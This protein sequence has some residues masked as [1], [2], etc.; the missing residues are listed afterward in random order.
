MQGDGG[1]ERLKHVQDAALPV[2]A[3]QIMEPTIGGN[4][5]HA[6]HGDAGR[7][8]E[9][10]GE[11]ARGAGSDAVDPSMPA[12]FGEF[13]GATYADM[14]RLAFLLTGSTETARDLVQDSYLRV[15]GAWD[16]VS[17]PRPYLRRAVV[18]ACNSHHR[19]TR[20]QRQHAASTRVESVSLDAEEMADAI[21]ALPYRQRAAIV[22]RFWHDC[23]EVEIAAALGCRPGT[24]GSL[25]HRALAELRR[26]IP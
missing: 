4:D 19:R 13:Y 20:R 23:T 26:V 22:L 16:R 3:L 14:V 12:T 1:P 7:P 8:S 21:S 25:I 15:H 9:P 5:E 24:V 17:E 11:V 2:D 10:P 18:N 6:G